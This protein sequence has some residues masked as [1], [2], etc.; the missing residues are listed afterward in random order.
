MILFKIP[1]TIFEPL[2]ITVGRVKQFAG[3]ELMFN[4]SFFLAVL[5]PVVLD[6]SMIEILWWLVGLY[7]IHAIVVIFISL[8]VAFNYSSDEQQHASFTFK[9]QVKYSLPL[10]LSMNVLELS[11]YVDKLVVSNQ[12]S[13]GDYAIYTRGAME[14]PVIG[15]IA[16]TLDNLHMP[17]FVQFYKDNNIKELMSVW[18]TSVRFMAAFIY[19]CC[20]FLIVSAPLLIPAIFSDKYIGS[21]II[22]QVY[23]LGM[24]SRISTFDIILRVIGKTKIILIAALMSVFVNVALTY[25]LM[26]MWGLIGAP[27]ATIITLFFMRLT[28]LIAITHHFNISLFQVF[29]WESLCK[30][31]V[32]ASL[33]TLPV[34]L[35]YSLELNVWVHLL[36]MACV[37]SL[38]YL[39]LMKFMNALNEEDKDSLKSILPKKLSWII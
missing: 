14:I 21:I 30:S 27:I 10:G 23:A 6:S 31:L 39:V 26:A 3:V 15:I 5:I 38:S 35:V 34:F 36:I 20:L 16:S 32:A 12:S 33:S 13:A 28:Y 25:S 9:E 22:F 1:L 7:S 24:L 19:P 17:N 37:F 8:V 4:L 11:R 18:H 2:M 29:P